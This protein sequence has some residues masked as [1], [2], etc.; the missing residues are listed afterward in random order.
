MSK[1]YYHNKGQ[2]DY[3]RGRYE[4][5]HGIL[6]EFLRWSESGMREVREDNSAYDSGWGHAKSQ[7]R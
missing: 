4:K 6:D 3:S 2:E 1:E 5:P 7:D